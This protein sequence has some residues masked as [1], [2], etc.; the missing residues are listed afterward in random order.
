MKQPANVRGAS[1]LGKLRIW[2]RMKIKTPKSNISFSHKKHVAFFS[3][4]KHESFGFQNTWHETV[5]NTDNTWTNFKTTTLACFFFLRWFVA[6]FSHQPTSEAPLKS[7]RKKIPP[8]K[9]PSDRKNPSTRNV[10]FFFFG[11]EKKHRWE[12]SAG[13]FVGFFFRPFPL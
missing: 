12:I 13:F 7:H 2:K 5:L 3:Q 4:T 10:F 1:G 8:N 11:T 6:F 9:K